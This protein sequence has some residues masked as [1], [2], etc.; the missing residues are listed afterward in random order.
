MSTDRNNI[1][2]L[3]DMLDEMIPSILDDLADSMREKT[4]VDTG[5]LRD[6]IEIDYDEMLILMRKSE[7]NT[8]EKYLA[9]EYGTR[10]MSGSG[11]V[12]RSVALLPSI[13]EKRLRG[14]K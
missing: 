12:R 3:V 14:R 1:D 10:S 5:E 7:T 2:D 11:F 4:F 9:N 8:D 13:V 6:S